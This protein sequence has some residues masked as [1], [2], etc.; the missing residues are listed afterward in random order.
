MGLFITSLLLVL[1][2]GGAATGWW[3]KVDPYLNFPGFEF[4][5][6]MNLAIFVGILIKLLRKPLGDAFK[7]KREAIRAELIDAEREKQLA[8][9]RLT[10]VEGKLAQLETEKGEILAQ[11]AKEAEAE[12]SRIAREAEAEVSRIKSQ[13]AGDLERKAQQIRRQLRRYSAE[14][15]VRLA[16]EKIKSQIN[17]EKDAALIKAGI[18]SI[19]G[20]N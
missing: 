18:Q 16:E 20:V 10:T 12:K 2:G 8:L 4:W 6:F 5:R 19:G 9:A 13:A 11:A 17:A 1:A 7:A 3:S 15:S 14:E